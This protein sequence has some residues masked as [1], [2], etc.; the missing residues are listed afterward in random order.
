MRKAVKVIMSV[1]MTTVLLI[2][3]LGF[4]SQAADLIHDTENPEVL[5]AEVIDMGEDTVPYTSLGQCIISISGHDDGMYIDIT[6]G[7]DGT[8]SVIGVKDIKIERKF[9]YG[10]STVATCSG[11][12]IHDRTMMGICITYANAVKDATY[13]ISCVHYADVNGY[14]EGTNDT[15]AFVYT[16]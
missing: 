14:T 8:A 2:G 16:Y 3:N 7:A 11:G 6:T 5:E 15:G 1:V 10:W 13:R 4:T 9:W 12:E